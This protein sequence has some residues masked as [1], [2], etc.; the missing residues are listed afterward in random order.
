MEP[1]APQWFVDA[2]TV[3]YE[4][5]TVDVA[6]CPIHY[7]AWGEPGRPGLV[8]VHGGAAHAHWWSFIAA[9]FADQYRVVAVDLSGHGDSGHRPRYDLHTWTKEVLISAIDAECRG[10]PIVVGHSMGGFVAI[11]TAALHGEQLAGAIVCD[12]AVVAPDPELVQAAKNHAFSDPKIYPDEDTA[13]ARFKT[14][15]PQDHYEPYVKEFVARTSLRKV[16]GGFTWKFDP[17]IFSS[18]HASNRNIAGEL[19]PD[20]RCRV[21]LLRS[22]HG[23]VTDDIAGYMYDQLGR[24]AP[25]VN[26]PLA[27]HHLMLDQPLLT[28]TAVRALVSDWE[29]SVPTRR[30]R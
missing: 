26:I 3:P 30:P 6:G 11:A 28:L 27:G 19:L 7:L 20:V 29:H 5:R 17:S 23:I 1:S 14:I 4:D 25:V 13:V 10:A 9:Q 21:A 8:F 18:M 24:N 22:E 2:L 12:S 16:E 15:P